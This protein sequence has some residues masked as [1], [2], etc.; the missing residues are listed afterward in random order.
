MSEK[1]LIPQMVAKNSMDFLMEHGY[2]ILGPIGSS[3]D[4]LL[5]NVSAVDAILLRSYKVDME[6][7][8]GAKNLQIVARHGAGF[9]NV[10]IVKAAEL[11]IWVTNT[12]L[13]TNIAVGEYAIT[14]MLLLAKQVP[15]MID[16]LKKGDFYIRMKQ[17]GMDVE[18]KT[19][20]II[21]LGRI[22]SEVAKRAINGFGMQVLAFDPFCRPDKV[23]AGVQL[24]SELKDVLKVS[25][26]VTLHM[27]STPETKKM[28]SS[29][30][31]AN[32][33]K[34]A[35]II[36]CA[37][38]EVVDETALI[39]ALEA[40]TIAGAAIDVYDLEPPSMDNPLLHMPN[41]IATPHIASNTTEANAKMAL[42]AAQEIH[43]V[44]S[45]EKPLWPVNKPLNPRNQQ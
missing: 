43:R 7:L 13:A 17:W 11:G 23:P 38:G 45:G 2:E 22:G 24:L 37:R 8:G 28:F 39:K 5:C 1:I 3:K 15:L 16:G 31:F 44:L 30:Q 20:G 29:G 10:D 42:H 27:P 21:G 4:E 33:K 9:D 40:G 19:L 18:G 41:V 36:N 34:T 14:A 26:F 35:Y 32:M 6:V 25:D 12:P